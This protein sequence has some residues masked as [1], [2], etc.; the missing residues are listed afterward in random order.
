MTDEV[1]APTVLATV[2]WAW[3]VMLGCIIAFSGL[4]LIVMHGSGDSVDRLILLWFRASDGSGRGPAWFQESVSD[5]TALGSYPTILLAL[6]FSLCALMICRRY[7]ASLF[8]VLAIA[9]G[10][11]ASTVLKLIFTRGRPDLVEPLDRTFSASFPS[12]HAMLSMLAWLTMA[13]LVAR[14]LQVERLRYLTLASAVTLSL[15]IGISRIYLG[16]HWPTD[17]LAGWI[18]GL[19]W[20]SACWLLAHYLSRRQYS[21]GRFGKSGERA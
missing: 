6:I 20:A 2:R 9:T 18:A 17:V 4:A 13:A 19:G 15:L 12:A 14:F 5:I 11:V 21:V 7:A 10:S 8:L 16:V 3:F 1:P